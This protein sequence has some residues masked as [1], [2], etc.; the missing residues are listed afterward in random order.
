MY[1][2]NFVC[3]F[4]N[5]YK[6]IK[7]HILFSFFHY[8]MH[9]VHCQ[10]CFEF[11]Y[12]FNVQLYFIFNMYVISQQ[13]F[14]ICWGRPSRIV[15]QPSKKL[16][17]KLKVEKRIKGDWK[18]AKRSLKR[19]WTSFQPLQT[20][21]NLFQPVFDLFSTSF[22]FESYKK[23]FLLYALENFILHASVSTKRSLDT[24]K[25]ISIL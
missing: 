1:Y 17:L 15:T 21:F 3:E 13:V 25:I 5:C 10:K 8:I 9:L 16:E 6:I 14:Q 24:N 2:L 23:Q 12:T 4:K 20:I 7:N 18:E 11:H 19:G 22:Y